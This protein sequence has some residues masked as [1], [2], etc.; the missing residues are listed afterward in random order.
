MHAGELSVIGDESVSKMIILLPPDD[1]TFP[2]G[3]TVLHG[4]IMTS[5]HQIKKLR[6]VV[7]LL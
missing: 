1:S 3:I 5:I 6:K 7:C 2:F 4:Y